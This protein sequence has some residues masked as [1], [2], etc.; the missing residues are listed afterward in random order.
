MKKKAYIIPQ[1][2]V[3]DAEPEALM[4]SSITEVSG[5]SG[6]ELG[7]GETPSTADSRWLGAWEEE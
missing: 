2:D 7:E 6:I 5:D 3:M 1:V 4:V